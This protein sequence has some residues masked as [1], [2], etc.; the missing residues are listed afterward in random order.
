MR[1]AG[2]LRTITI[3]VNK[4]AEEPT[5]EDFTQAAVYRVKVPVE[6]VEKFP[7]LLSIDYQGDC[8]R[9]YVGGRLVAD[10]FN[11]GRPFLYGLWRLPKGCTELELRILPM[12]QDEP[13][14]F[15]READTTPGEKVKS[16]S[17]TYEG[18]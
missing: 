14:Y 13:V 9:L 16:I 3:G 7:R 6:A 4:V 10:H 2:P 15:P 17:I 11:N 12:Q 1:E 5:D 8:A 18:L